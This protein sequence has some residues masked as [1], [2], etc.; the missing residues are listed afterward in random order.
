M[1]R[2]DRTPAPAAAPSHMSPHVPCFNRDY[3]RSSWA[4]R[5][6]PSSTGPGG[7]ARLGEAPV[8]L[9]AAAAYRCSARS[10]LRELSSL[11]AEAGRLERSAA[12]EGG[13]QGEGGGEGNGCGMQFVIRALWASP[14]GGAA[15]G[16]KGSSSDPSPPHAP[17]GPELEP[18]E[19]SGLRQPWLPR[20][21]GSSAIRHHE[22]RGRGEAGSV[23]RGRGR[24]GPGGRGGG[25]PWGPARPGP[26][27][28]SL[29]PRGSPRGLGACPQ[30]AGPR[31]A[32]A[33]LVEATGWRMLG[34]WQWRSLHA[35]GNWCPL[36]RL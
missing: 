25:W 16:G 13:G 2:E 23:A 33:K 27:R 22:Q 14:G 30:G 3:H 24:A 1:R 21:A 26:A 9:R 8:G 35:P 34:G 20:A 11:Q 7:G 31:R 10:V 5:S 29:P 32:G 18:C 4:G 36:L 19:P 15:P 12:M 28:S 17:P 6:S